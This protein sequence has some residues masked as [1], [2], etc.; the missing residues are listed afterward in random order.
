MFEDA[1]LSTKI[2]EKA[3]EW[4]PWRAAVAHWGGA[5]A[6]PRRAQQSSASLPGVSD[7]QIFGD[8]SVLYISYLCTFLYVQVYIS[9]FKRLNTIREDEWWV[10]YSTDSSGTTEQNYG[11]K[12]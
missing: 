3:Q 1:Y 11:K 2:K 12:Y 4:L 6:G 10:Y 7:T 8:V 9:Q 5:L